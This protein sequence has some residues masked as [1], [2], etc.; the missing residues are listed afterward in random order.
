[1]SRE[2]D[3]FMC[4]G[5]PRVQKIVN[6]QQIQP[7]GDVLGVLILGYGARSIILVPLS[8]AG[9]ELGISFCFL[10]P[11]CINIVVFLGL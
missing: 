6:V 10:P 4:L 5:V 1:M 2:E 8:S 7:M 11:F 3:V 9:F